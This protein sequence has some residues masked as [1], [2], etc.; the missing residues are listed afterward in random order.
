M[1]S[2]E[3]HREVGSLGGVAGDRR[4]SERE[5]GLEAYLFA[6]LE[7]HTN[8]GAHS[9]GLSLDFPYH[10]GDK[11]FDLFDVA[12]LVILGESTHRLLQRLHV[13]PELAKE[14]A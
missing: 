13:V 1:S 5:A 2:R 9:F 4:V 6:D 10:R 3:R 11:G 14:D 8:V 12:A 7:A